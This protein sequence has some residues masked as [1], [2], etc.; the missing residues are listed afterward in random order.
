MLT[1]MPEIKLFTIGFTQ[2]TA[3]TF[4]TMLMKAK[5]RRILDVRLNNKSQ[6]AGFAKKN[7]LRYFLKTIGSVG[8]RHLP[9][10]APTKTILDDY[11]KNKSDWCVYE[12]QFSDLMKTRRIEAQMSE[13]LKDGDCLLCSE[14]KPE[15]CHRRLVAEYLRDTQLKIDI[16]HLY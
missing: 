16:V 13:I 3:E 9:E 5:V 10:L 2:K 14:N 4:F 1:V 15:H 11:K 12:E 6:L 8:Y 7:D